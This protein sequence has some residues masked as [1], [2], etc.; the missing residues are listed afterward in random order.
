ML[1]QERKYEDVQG[2]NIL[3]YGQIGISIVWLFLALISY[4]LSCFQRTKHTVKRVEA[5]YMLILVIIFMTI[6]FPVKNKLNERYTDESISDLVNEDITICE[7][8]H[9]YE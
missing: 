4:G 9:I 5:C 7:L 6:G 1:I 8:S 3:V 2:I